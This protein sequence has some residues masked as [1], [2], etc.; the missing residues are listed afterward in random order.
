MKLFSLLLFAL[1]LSLPAQDIQTFTL[2]NTEFSI[3]I[4]PASDGD[5]LKDSVAQLYRG[6][7]LLLSHVLV[8]SSTDCNSISTEMGSYEVSDSTITFYTFWAKGGDAPVSPYGAR[9]QQ[10]LVQPDG[11]MKLISSALYE[12]YAA[13]KMKNIESYIESEG[14]L[15]EAQLDSARMTFQKEIETEYHAQ[16]IS[17][18][19][20]KK[21]MN[22][23]RRKLNE[24]YIRETQHWD[25]TYCRESFGCKK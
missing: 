17:A 14:E 7:K 10:Y 23:V 25:E 4:A 13:E 3:R 11:K 18:F 24:L 8:Q 1:P 21:L 5:W 16:W 19:E 20:G 15:T 12:T 6:D 2:R 22:E 9:M